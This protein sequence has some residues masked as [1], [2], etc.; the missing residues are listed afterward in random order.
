[1]TQVCV[2]QDAFVPR[3][4][5]IAFVSRRDGN[6]EIYRMKADGSEPTNLTNHPGSDTSPVWDPTGERIAF[7]S[8]RDGLVQLFVMNLDGS[9]LVRVSGGQAIGATWSPGGQAVAFASDRSGASEI[10]RVAIDG[11]ALTQL[12][13]TGGSGPDWSSDDRILFID[14]NGISVMASDGTAPVVIAPASVLPLPINARWKPDGSRIAVHARFGEVVYVLDSD[15]GNV[16]DITPPELA[17][18]MPR[19]SPTR[20]ELALTDTLIPGWDVWVLDAAGAAT[21]NLSMAPDAVDSVP[22]WSPDGDHVIFA[23]DRTGDLDLYRVTRDGVGLT[24]LTSTPADDTAA[25]WRPRP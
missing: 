7:L 22:D 11:T 18:F 1:V 3:E 4:D 5:Y 17:Y 14:A 15:G 10:W 20:N 16:M 6:D 25:H 12:T 19:W 24:N 8:D 21:R 23:S 9:G 2:D 13:N